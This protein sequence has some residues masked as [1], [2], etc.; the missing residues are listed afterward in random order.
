[1][2]F[3][4][5]KKLSD[6][7]TDLSHVEPPLNGYE[8]IDKFGDVYRG[9]IPDDSFRMSEIGKVKD[10]IKEWLEKDREI[11]QHLERVLS[12][13]GFEERCKLKNKRLLPQIDDG[14]LRAVRSSRLSK[15]V[16]NDEIEMI[17]PNN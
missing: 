3:I 9:E 10:M 16:L 17:D 1:M 11:V 6:M 13:R 15:L 5:A 4:W 7:V 2:L 14:N 8:N 12:K